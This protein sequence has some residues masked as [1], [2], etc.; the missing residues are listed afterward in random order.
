[1]PC[2][3][4]KPLEGK[5][6][7][8]CQNEVWHARLHFDCMECVCCVV[9]GSIMWN[10][11]AQDCDSVKREKNKHK[12]FPFWPSLDMICSH[13]NHVL[14]VYARQ[15][16]MCVGHVEQILLQG[17]ATSC[18][19]STNKCGDRDCN[20]SSLNQNKSMACWPNGVK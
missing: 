16:G 15:G 1:M 7:T 5:L 20:R 3:E 19:N 8:L 10:E 17:N 13:T 11:R 12:H 4:T 9:F 18:T 2:F 6:V 14:L